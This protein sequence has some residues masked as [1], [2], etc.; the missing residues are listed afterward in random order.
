MPP[1]TAAALAAHPGTGGG[2]GERRG[3]G[4]QRGRCPAGSAQPQLPAAGTG[5][6]RGEPCRDRRPLQPPGARRCSPGSVGN[7]PEHLPHPSEVP[8][9][10]S[11]GRWG[12]SSHPA[13]PGARQPSAPPEH[14]PGS[15][16]ALRGPWQAAENKTAARTL[17]LL[18]RARLPA[19]RMP[20]R[21]R[22]G[23]GSCAAGMAPAVPPQRLPC[24][25][26]IPG[27]RQAQ[28]TRDRHGRGQV[29]SCLVLW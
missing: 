10:S 24:P 8:L 23:R 29:L 2:A 25:G 18:P 21:L 16:A 3:P 12:G 28:V 22:R 26:G 19:P 1:I 7:D 27:Q 14:G 20:A 13:G 5:R 11:Q 9:G 6:H 15:A 17:W 4:S